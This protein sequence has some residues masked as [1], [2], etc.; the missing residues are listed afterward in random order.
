MRALEKLEKLFIY[1]VKEE[2]EPQE[3]KFI[4]HRFVK[5]DKIRDENI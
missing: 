1:L 5:D 4:M 3:E 2:E